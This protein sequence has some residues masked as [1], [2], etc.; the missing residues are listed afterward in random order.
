MENLYV[1]ILILLAVLIIDL[2]VNVIV[3][4][5]SLQATKKMMKNNEENLKLNQS[6]STPDDIENCHKIH[7]C[8]AKILQH[9]LNNISS[10]N[11]QINKPFKKGD[12][13][14]YFGFMDKTNF[15]GEEHFGIVIED[16]GECCRVLTMKDHKSIV[17]HKSII[18]KMTEKEK[19]EIPNL[20]DFLEYF[21]EKYDVENVEKTN[22]NMKMNSDESADK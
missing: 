18:G 2:T 14:H 7:V 5:Q 8:D 19:E 15:I 17:C 9:Q 21:H 3:L 13:I 11:F 20:K 10:V 16:R 22:T 4:F 12:L 1:I 6:I